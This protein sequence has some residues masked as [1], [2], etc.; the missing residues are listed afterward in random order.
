MALTMDFPT[1]NIEEKNATNYWTALYNYFKNSPLKQIF[2]FSE[3]VID[4]ETFANT[5]FTFKYKS[6]TP[7]YK[8]NNYSPDTFS[9]KANNAALSTILFTQTARNTAY[10]AVTVTYD[11]SGF[12]KNIPIKIGKSLEVIYM[13]LLGKAKGDP[14]FIFDVNGWGC[15]YIHP[16]YY[17]QFA[18]AVSLTSVVAY[19]KISNDGKAYAGKSK[20]YFLKPVIR[21]SAI[22]NGLYALEGGET[23]SN[24][25]GDFK[26]NGD[27]YWGFCLQ[28]LKQ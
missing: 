14:V 3:L 16:S 8:V 17:Y 9:L 26:F 6:N 15:S 18:Y 23:E 1:S 20:R 22:F 19:A 13:F 4:T 27:D 7:L 24:F 25:S 5:G 2:D 10:S 21:G 12:T 11:T 28:R